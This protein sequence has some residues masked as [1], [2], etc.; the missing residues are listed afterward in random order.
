MPSC[1]LEGS[2][3][4][5][6]KRYFPNINICKIPTCCR[7]KILTILLFCVYFH[8][9]RYKKLSTSSMTSSILLRFFKKIFFLHFTDKAFP[10]FYQDSYRLD[11]QKSFWTLM[12]YQQWISLYPYYDMKVST[13]FYLYCAWHTNQNNYVWI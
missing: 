13:I 9:V 10:Q 6:Y 1:E 7:P 8:N 4:I 3:V 2:K 12:S 11:C 5:Y